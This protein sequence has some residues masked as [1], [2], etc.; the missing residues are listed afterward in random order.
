PGAQA[1]EL[2]LEAAH[3]DQGEHAPDPLGR[4]RMRPRLDHPAGR[5]HRR[6]RP[7][8]VPQIPLVVDEAGPFCAGHRATLTCDM[9]DELTAVECLRR[10]DAG[11]LSAVELA[12]DTLS[13][14]EAASDL[15]AV[16]A[17]DE[18]ATLAAAAEADAARAAGS[19]APLLGLPLT[20][21]D[22]IA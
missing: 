19:E 14:L 9:L 6:R 10:L 12:R 17:L 1:D 15:N 7:R 22:T 20:I 3:L 8:E 5:D 4:L 2:L 11:E 21:K 18:E 16:A 13:R